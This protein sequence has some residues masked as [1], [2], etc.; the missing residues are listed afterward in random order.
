MQWGMSYKLNIKGVNILKILLRYLRAI[1]VLAKVCL[2]AFEQLFFQMPEQ[3]FLCRSLSCRF[4]TIYQVFAY[5]SI[6][7]DYKEAIHVAPT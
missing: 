3:E 7:F 1:L 2:A 6:K 4:S 5:W